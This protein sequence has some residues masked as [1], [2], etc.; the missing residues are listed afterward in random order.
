ML[1]TTRAGTFVAGSNRLDGASGAAWLALLPRQEFGS[2]LVLGVP[3]KPVLAALAR[4]AG[5]VTVRCR[6]GRE[7]RR[8]RVILAG[9]AA[10]IVGEIPQ[11]RFDLVVVARS[12]ARSFDGALA[13]DATVVVEESGAPRRGHGATNATRIALRPAV[14]EITAAVP[15]S[16]PNARRAL[17][18]RGLWS[19]SVV[20]RAFGR[21]REVGGPWLRALRERRLVVGA[22]GPPAYLRRIAA[23]AGIDI[24]AW[25]WAMSAP[26]RYR[27]NKISFFLFEPGSA[28]PKLVVKATRDPDLNGRLEIERGALDHL[29]AARVVDPSTIPRVAFSGVEAGRAVLG[30]TAVDGRP[31]TAATRATADCPHAARAFG[32]LV[33][34]G[35]ATATPASGAELAAHLGD[36]LD[37]FLGLYPVGAAYR[38][39]LEAQIRVIEDSASS[40]PSVLQHGDPGVWN[41]LVAEDGTVA[42]LDWEAAEHRGVPLWDVFH[43]ARSFAVAAGRTGGETNIMRAIETI[44]FAPTPINR[45]VADAIGR[46]RDRVGVPTELIEPLFHTSWMHRALKEATR[47]PKERLEGGHYLALLRRGID[48]RDTAGVRRLLGGGE[49]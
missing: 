41:L 23:G 9:S 22:S 48:L 39:M 45:M 30:L 14:G 29:R 1:D 32:W 35:A 16:S 44:L 2:V 21:S 25:D 8:A 24:D 4:A 18:R 47:L 6:T 27:S 7:A 5:A 17:E 37:R 43:L 34:L 40:F 12:E 3:G 36:I 28:E 38:S 20:I 11:G 10:Q 19:G 33:D 31:F 13:G 49:G 26:G 15:E 46:Y 42:F